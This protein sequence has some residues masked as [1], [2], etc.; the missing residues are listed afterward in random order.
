MMLTTR[1][2]ILAIL[3]KQ[4]V[5][6]SK[7]LSQNLG[8]TR[9]NILHHLAILDADHL[10][11]T[12]GQ[13]KSAR[14]RPENLYGLSRQALGNDLVGLSSVLIEHALED[15]KQTER[16]NYLRNLARR[17][18]A[19]IPDTHTNSFSNMLSQMIQYLNQMHYHARWE[20]S[21]S[22]A[23]LVFNHCPYWALIDNHP[24]L[25]LLDKYLLE[26][27]TKREIAQVS[28]LQKQDRHLPQCSFR[29]AN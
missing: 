12:I 9:A 5:L 29:I 28:K 25:C 3:E 26:E 13:R 4:Q 17:Y 21:A 27:W 11:E 23:L 24:E 20:A 16:S 22:G 18:R 2:K 10:I 6:T 14:G 19:L 15:M 1:Q 7:E 8:F